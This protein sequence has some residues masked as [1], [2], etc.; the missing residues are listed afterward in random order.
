MALVCTV[1]VC[2]L[3]WVWLS[4]IVRK[5]QIY[6]ICDFYCQV[7]R[8]KPTGPVHNAFVKVV[9]S[10]NCGNDQVFDNVL[11]DTGSAV[12]WVGGEEA[13]VPGPHT[14][15][16]NET[17]S[18]GY[19]AGG[20]NGT[21]FLDTV[22]IGEAKARNAV[23]GSAAFLSGFSLVQ[24]IDGIL[25]L[26]PSGSNAGQVGSNGS[27]TPTFV[28][29]LVAS[30]AISKPVFGIYISPLTAEGVPEGT[31]DITFGGVDHSRIKGDI[32]WVPQTGPANFHWEF[33]TSTFSFGP[34]VKL[35]TSTF[36]RTDTGVL[37]IAIPFDQFFDMLHAYN[38]STVFDQSALSTFLTFPSNI[39]HLLPDMTF[40][41]N[42][43][44]YIVPPSLYPALN[45]TADPSIT[46]TW[47]GSGGF[48]GFVL[49]QK[50]LEN[51]YT[52]YDKIG[53]AHLA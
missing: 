4:S 1:L 22:T 16:I 19:G 52:A 5:C 29:S 2:L 47:I 37:P 43:F 26:G 31:G 42:Q 24:P 14:E 33:N 53:F 20:V 30:K 39:T 15:Y 10:V 7:E 50:W 38:G 27:S 17:F 23:I 21:A 45:V 3:A 8:A 49:G 25:G 35:S 41:I 40:T 34:K 9:A 32:T 11:V 46:R 44:T 13:Y 48:G 6:N 12:L 51:V 36:T 28:E 18:V